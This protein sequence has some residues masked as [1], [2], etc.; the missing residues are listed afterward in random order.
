M[1]QCEVVV[2]DGVCDREPADAVLE[3]ADAVV[4][5]PCREG[6]VVPAEQLYSNYA[7][8]IYS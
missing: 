1:K 3:K 8:L 2:D 5:L 6:R 7:A 4:R